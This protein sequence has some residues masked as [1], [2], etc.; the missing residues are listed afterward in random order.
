LIGA[1]A[2]FRDLDLENQ[3]PKPA[4]AMLPVDAGAIAPKTQRG[5]SSG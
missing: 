4:G 5:E 3:L 1:R 2:D